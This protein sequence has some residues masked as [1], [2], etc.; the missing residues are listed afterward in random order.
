[1]NSISEANKRVTLVKSEFGGSSVVRGPSDYNV[2]E[3]RVAA[4]SGRDK[5]EV[6]VL[7]VHG[8]TGD[9]IK[10]WGGSLEVP[11]ER[12]ADASTR[13]AFPGGLF[14]KLRNAGA[15]LGKLVKLRN[16]LDRDPRCAV[17]TEA[18]VSDCWVSEL[19]IKLHE[20]AK[21]WTIGYPTAIWDRRLR[22]IPTSIGEDG[23]AAL[24][25]LR[26]AG[27]GDRPIVFVAHSLGGLLTKAILNKSAEADPGSS[28][29]RI[30]EQTHR[31]IFISTPHT[32][33]VHAKWRLL[34]PPLLN[35]ATK[36]V[37]FLAAA[38]AAIFLAKVAIELE[39]F[40]LTWRIAAPTIL[41]LLVVL[42][43]GIW[44][45]KR[46]APGRHVLLLDPNEPQLRELKQDFRRIHSRRTFSTVSFYEQKRLCGLFLVVP[47]W[48]ADPG[49]TDCEPIPIAADHIGIC[50]YGHDE[51]WRSIREGVESACL[52]RTIPVFRKEI[53][54]LATDSY[55]EAF[56]VLFCS[57]SG[58]RGAAEQVFRPFLRE[59]IKQEEFIPNLPI[60]LEQV[61]LR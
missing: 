5:H 7:L 14:D 31:V 58:D 21:F 54:R 19:A 29:R 26:D 33:S 46:L 47:W 37:G 35:L 27:F 59:K 22:T 1:V 11:D 30:F 12:G 50:K 36:G 55:K 53:E 56:K 57:G 2:S 49:V 3:F 10:T 61:G 42:L 32:G 28:E 15:F 43:L 13:A 40:D 20:Q 48:S 25:A 45:Q 34:V 4:A 51:L 52:G 23:R 41:G 9:P 17:N 44:V 18:V 60:R 24:G 38:V 16:A 39:I 8:L 6:D